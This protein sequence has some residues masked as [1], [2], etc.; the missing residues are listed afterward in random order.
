M[1]GA[2]TLGQWVRKISQEL[3]NLYPDGAQFEAELLLADVLGRP[4][5]Y[6]YASPEI[7]PSPQQEMQ[8]MAYLEA[9]LQGVPLAYILGHT[10]FY[11]LR[12]RVQQGVLIPRPET[13]VLVEIARNW[14]GQ[15]GSD[16]R[17]LKCVDLGCGTGCVGISVLDRNPE[18]S[19][20]FVDISELALRNT[21]ENLLAFGFAS[22]ASVLHQSAEA[23]LQRSVPLDLI[24]ANPPYVDKGDPLVEFSVRQYEP[25]LAVFADDAGMAKI[26]SWIQGALAPLAEGGLLLMEFGVGQEEELKNWLPRVTSKRFEFYKDLSQRTRG[27]ALYG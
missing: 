19:F 17:K 11:G 6:L 3:K 22:R 18:L 16:L 21:L 1:T 2:R 7:I 20:D 14:L 23:Y 25:A 9:R 10:E 13:E 24:L 5:S 8:L 27:V 15:Q 4:R 26:K 12:F